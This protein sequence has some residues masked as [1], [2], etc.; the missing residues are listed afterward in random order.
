M[1]RRFWGCAILLAAVLV[2]AAP[3]AARPAPFRLQLPIPSPGHISIKVVKVTV[4]GHPRGLPKHLRLAPRRARSLPPSVRV[5]Y[6][7]TKTRGKRSTIYRLVV[8]AVN[9]AAPA[10]SA[11]DDGPSNGTELSPMAVFLMFMGS[12]NA[13]IEYDRQ[14][15]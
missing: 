13:A 1:T 9:V 8:I 12:P 11:A 2:A 5:I 10:A 14:N 4:K 7:Q 6:A 15:L 3:A